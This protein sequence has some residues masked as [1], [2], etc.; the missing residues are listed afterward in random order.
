MNSEESYIIELIKQKFSETD[1]LE[2]LKDSFNLSIEDARTR[3]IDVIN[4]LK[5]LQNTFNHKKITIKNN[6]GFLTVFKKTS[7]NNLSITIENIDNINYL[8]TIPM[9]IDSLTKI[10]FNNIDD[11]TLKLEIANICKK[12][13]PLDDT[14][15]KTFTNMEATTNTNKNIN[16]LLEDDDDDDINVD[17]YSPNNDLMDILLDDDDDE[18]EEEDEEDEEEEQDSEEDDQ[19]NEDSKNDDQDNEEDDIKQEDEVKEEDFKEDFEYENEEEVKDTEDK[20]SII[21]NNPKEKEYINK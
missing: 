21:F 13:Q 12:A 16:H 5:L 18:E 8:D 1:I 20:D 3:L 19:D 11:D 6:P 14:K 10:L 17:S 15:E 9:Y 2:K 7:S 4:S